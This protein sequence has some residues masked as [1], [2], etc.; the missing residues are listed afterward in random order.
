MGYFLTNANL[1]ER[2]QKV[3]TVLTYLRS[4]MGYVEM[5]QL[6]LRLVGDAETSQERC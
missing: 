4:G 2:R 6:V 5:P 3:Q 1:K